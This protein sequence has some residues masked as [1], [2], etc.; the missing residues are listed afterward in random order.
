MNIQVV[1]FQQEESWGYRDEQNKIV[2][3][4]RFNYAHEFS[5]S[6]AAVKIGEKWG[7]TALCVTKRYSNSSEQNNFR[8]AYL[9]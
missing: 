5:E 7:Y 8:F 6:L 3:P 2:I 9:N 4:P 1:P